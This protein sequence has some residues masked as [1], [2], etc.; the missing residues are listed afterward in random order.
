M[1]NAIQ[2][3]GSSSIM[4]D[5]FTRSKANEGVNFPLYLPSGEKSE[6]WLRVR[7]V[8]SDRFRQAE[9]NSKRD[10]LRIMQIEDEAERDEAVVQSKCA[11]IS[12]LV[13]A[14]S[15]DRPCTPENVQAFFREA[16]Q[17]MDA[18]DRA[19]SK[20]ALFFVGRSSNSLPTPSENSS[21]T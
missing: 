2:A 13:V 20:R 4:E 3:P 15:F 1:T 8:D 6:H 18:V 5:F 12:S 21:S 9:L 19:A 11:L 10:I 14:W 17:I 16:P 7:G